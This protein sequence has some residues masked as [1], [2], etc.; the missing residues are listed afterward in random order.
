LLVER[1]L[2]ERNGR[3]VCESRSSRIKVMVLHDYQANPHV[4]LSVRAES[5]YTNRPSSISQQAA[6]RRSLQG[7]P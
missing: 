2:R 4:R 6:L 5:N 1:E 3:G 7:C